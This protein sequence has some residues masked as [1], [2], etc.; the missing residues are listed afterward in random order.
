VSLTPAAVARVL[1][2]DDGL[3]FASIE[4]PP[5][6]VW[7]WAS[8]PAL[9]TYDEPLELRCSMLGRDLGGIAMRC[10]DESY[11]SIAHLV[12]PPEQVPATMRRPW[13]QE[14][15]EEHSCLAAVVAFSEDGTLRTGWA[16][17]GD[18]LPGDDDT[19]TA[20]RFEA[21]LMTSIQR[22]LLVAMQ[23]PLNDAE[24]RRWRSTGTSPHLL[25]VPRIGST[26]ASS[27]AAVMRHREHYNTAGVP[28]RAL[29]KSEARAQCAAHATLETYKCSICGALHVGNARDRLA[30]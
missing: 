6:D 2:L 3:P 17:F 23:P 27:T 8:T 9:L 24:R 11:S 7:P 19:S 5:I 22:R 28:K 26:L 15:F 4:Y 29:T 13:G 30:G 12:I 16:S 18:T 25:D 1:A 21:H 10:H 14:P 20:H